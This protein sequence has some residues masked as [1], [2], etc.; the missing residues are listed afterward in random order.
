MGHPLGHD[1][2]HLHAR[3]ER[4]EGVLEDDLGALAERAQLAP[5]GAPARRARRT[6]TEPL[7]RPGSA[8]GR[9]ARACSCRTRS[10]RPARASRRPMT[11]RSTPP[12]AASKLVGRPKKSRATGKRLVSPRTRSSGLSAGSKGVGLKQRSSR[13]SSNRS[14]VG[15]ASSQAAARLGQRGA[16]RQAGGIDPR[17]GTRPTITGSR[18]PAGV[19]DGHA[20]QQALGVG[21]PRVGEELGC[22]APS[23]R[24]RRRTSRRPGRRSRS[25]RRGRG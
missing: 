23:R 4:A 12:T 3:V 20:P 21:M 6:S 25:R 22:R 19:R 24:S 5:R 15:W 10:R 16:N 9:A 8:A 18:L 11:S 2:A 14:R 13:R 7:G 17:S 1:R